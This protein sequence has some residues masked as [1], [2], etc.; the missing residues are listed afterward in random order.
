MSN[1]TFT[2]K[3]LTDVLDIITELRE[4]IDGIKKDLAILKKTYGRSPWDTG[5]SNFGFNKD[6]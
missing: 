2:Q 4:D 5:A 1:I 6:A 3:N